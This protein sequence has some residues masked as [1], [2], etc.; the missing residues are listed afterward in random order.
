[1]ASK[2]SVIIPVYNVEQYL[3]K[4][5][6]SILNQT[7]KNIEIILVNDGSIDKSGLI[8]D[9]YSRKYNNIKVFHKENG[10]VSSARNLGIDNATGQYLAFI[11]PDDY[12]DAN[13]YEILV[14]K[15]VE[16][17]SDIAMCSFVY[18]KE[19]EN[20]VE[21]N[22][23]ETLVFDKEEVLRRYY[24]AIKPFNASFLFNKLFKKELFKEVRLDTELIIQEDTEV[25]LRI[26]NNISSIVYVGIPLYFYL[27]REGAATEGKISKGKLTTDISLFKIYKYTEEN[28]PKYKSNA[29]A[30]YVMY[31]FNIIVEIIKNYE[32]YGEYY[33]ILLKRFRKNYIR[34]LLDKNI[35]IKYKIHGAL[36]LLNKKLYKRYMESR[37]KNN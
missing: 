4:C 3:E 24:T 12:I 20:I 8:C 9:E 30:N 22:S 32:E 1:M 28:L 27:I 34:L 17:N 15:I 2:I 6:D 33:G 11:D 14:E 16:T 18:V 23:D 19:N 35:M 10:G 25:L 36:I 29:L 37:V 13:M 21:D 7:Y 5:L 31:Y 26:F